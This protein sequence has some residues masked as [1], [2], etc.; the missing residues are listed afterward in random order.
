MEVKGDTILLLVSCTVGIINSNKARLNRWWRLLEGIDSVGKSNVHAVLCSQ[1]KEQLHT[2]LFDTGGIGSETITKPGSRARRTI[3]T[4]MVFL[5]TRGLD[6]IAPL[7]MADL[8][9]LLLRERGTENRLAK[10]A[11]SCMIV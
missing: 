5:L 9:V 1:C 4:S 7:K 2:R 11:S 3:K 6:N 10:D 8:C